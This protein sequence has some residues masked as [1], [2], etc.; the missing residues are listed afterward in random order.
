M[1]VLLTYRFPYE[2]SYGISYQI[3]NLNFRLRYISYIEIYIS[4]FTWNTLL[5]ISYDWVS[6][7]V[8]HSS[9]EMTE[10]W[11]TVFQR[12]VYYFPFFLDL[13]LKMATFWWIST[14][15]I[16]TENIKN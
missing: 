16:F 4:N 13:P 2:I 3:S 7:F 8:V 5:E 12:A 9:T 11:Q 10:G 14:G 15:E 1:E 6:K